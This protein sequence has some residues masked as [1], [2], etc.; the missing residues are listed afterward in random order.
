ML[1]LLRMVVSSLRGWTG[2]SL[3]QMLNQKLLIV[4][5]FVLGSLGPDTEHRG[6][7][8][9][10]RGRGGGVIGLRL[11]AGASSVRITLWG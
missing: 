7:R 8:L 1:L 2:L 10:L 11:G 6:I 9:G 3:Q 5:N 4:I